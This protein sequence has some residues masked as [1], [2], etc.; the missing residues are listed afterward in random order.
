MARS[1][2]C[3]LFTFG[4]AVVL[5]GCYKPTNES[6]PGVK[7]SFKGTAEVGR[8]SP[9]IE[10]KDVDGKAMNLSDFRGKVVLLDF[11]ATY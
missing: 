9:D 10:G 8:P 2:S 6:A 1:R 3:W 4:L 5:A 11:W 7:S